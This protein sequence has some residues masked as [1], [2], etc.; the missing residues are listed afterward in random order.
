M[1]RITRSWHRPKASPLL[2]ST[3]MRPWV[4]VLIGL[5]SP[6]TGG[7]VAPE[8]FPS[9]GESASP[10]GPSSQAV[11]AETGSSESAFPRG[12]LPFDHL[13]GVYDPVP[14][15]G[16]SL[17][18]GRI[19][20]G[21]IVQG[22]S[23]SLGT[24]VTHDTNIFQDA[25]DPVSGM[26]L[27]TDLNL[28]FHLGQR[29]P[30]GGFLGIDYSLAYFHYL[31]EELNEGREPWEHNFSGLVG[32]KGA[33]TTVTL[34]GSFVQ[35]N[36]G[37][38][39]AV[40]IE[41]ETF[42]ERSNEYSVSLSAIR[43]LRR[44]SLN[45]GLSFRL[46]DFMDPEPARST[47]DA[48]VAPVATQTPVTAAPVT[49]APVTTN[50]TVPP[51]TATVVT[52]EASPP[53]P[54]EA[55]RDPGEN[56][57]TDLLSWSGYV[58]WS[59]TPPAA[60]KVDF[61]PT[62]SF[63][64]SEQADGVEQTYLNP[65]LGVMY[66]YNPKLAFFGSAGADLRHTDSTNSAGED[67][68]FDQTAPTFDL[69]ITWQPDPRTSLGVSISRSTSPS[70]LLGQSSSDTTSL[71][72]TA[73]RQFGRGISAAMDYSYE[74]ATYT[75]STGQEETDS[76]IGGSGTTTPKDF[77]RFSFTLGK[78]FELRG[79]YTLNASLFYQYILS[80]GDDSLSE[81]DQSLTGIRLG[82]NF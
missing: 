29:K 66:R 78:G 52:E 26:M 62:L 4:A 31:D 34:T 11:T 58:G 5:G 44:T 6:L 67:T 68:S 47:S 74:T 21:P 79:R 82:L 8:D 59:F 1:K 70:A 65:S 19:D 71:S 35:N 53:P 28:S 32:V 20:F 81:Y 18:P 16:P 9:M 76:G 42:Q 48:A 73:A 54:E 56:T 10:A 17:V 7:A 33:R 36:G 15:A 51:V 57:V 60:P 75:D 12:G 40:R 3:V 77:H 38:N 22:F 64:V 41:R 45:G 14:S 72:L 23:G 46:Q 43:R 27:S 50:S 24:S 2:E 25:E 39:N 61:R 37:A 13:F 63:G 69:G 55:E 80:E 30:I 49:L